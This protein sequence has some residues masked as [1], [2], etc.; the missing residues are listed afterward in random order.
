MNAITLG[1]GAV[2][3][4]QTGT[5]VRV[6]A[7]EIG[8]LRLRHVKEGRY[9]LCTEGEAGAVCTLEGQ[10]EHATKEGGPFPLRVFW[11]CMA[12]SN[13]VMVR[14]DSD[15][16]TMR[17]LKPGV[18]F[19]V[20]PGEIIR[21]SV[22]A[23]AAWAGLKEEDVNFLE[24]GAIDAAM[25]A[26]IDGKADACPGAADAP[27]AREL[28]GN[29]YGIRWLEVDPAKDPEAAARYL[30]VMPTGVFAMASPGCCSSAQGIVMEKVFQLY[31]IHENADPEMTY[32]LAKWV[33]ENFEVYRG[34]HPAS[35][36]MHFGALQS[37]LDTA[38]MPFHEGTVK[39]LKEKG[40]WTADHDKRQAYN[41]A[42]VN[43]YIEA[44]QAAIADA[45]AK[46][47][48]IHPRNEAWMNLWAEHKK[49]LPIFKVMAEIP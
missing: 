23:Y 11:S 27:W 43:R 22:L 41:L 44:Y 10:A 5:T 21:Q 38:F 29:P 35:A 45:E 1:W 3:E 2:L 32:R 31:F 47:I 26:V 36:G 28:E 18:T 49:D 16:K 9:D 33:D 37:N 13:G 34:A 20:H 39:Y 24:V 19:A 12:G 17:D 15:I 42:L 4:Q 46:G 25:R 6:T 14:G 30:E 40:V 48:D 8:A 7:E